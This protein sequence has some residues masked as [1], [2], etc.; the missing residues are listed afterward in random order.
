MF[1]HWVR[2]C[3]NEE[4]SYGASHSVGKTERKGQAREFSGGLV[5][6]IWRFH[7]RGPGSVPGRGIEIPQAI[8]CG[9]NFKKQKAKPA[10]RRSDH[11]GGQSKHSKDYSEFKQILLVFCYS[12]PNRLR[13]VH[14][15][16]Y[17]GLQRKHC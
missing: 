11:E 15:I 14:K 17:I 2:C 9:Q 8:R 1:Q 16:K 10:R 12:S 6:R 5:V 3:W 13:Q 4:R 7:C